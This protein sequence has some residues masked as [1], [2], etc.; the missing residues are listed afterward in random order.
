MKQL[1]NEQKN[2]IRDLLQAYV[3][4]FPSQNKAANSLEGVSSGTMSV[5]LN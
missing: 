2:E 4:R 1:T 3:S 5:I